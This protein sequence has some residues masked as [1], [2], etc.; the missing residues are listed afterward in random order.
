MAARPF[1]SLF[2]GCV[3]FVPAALASPSPQGP[4]NTAPFQVLDN[5][6]G[7]FVNLNLFPVRPLVAHPSGTGFFALN[8]HASTVERF[9]DTGSAPVEVWPVPWGPVAARLWTHPQTKQTQLLVSCRGSYV[10]ARLDATSGEVLGLIELP[11][12]PADVLVID[13]RA[14]VA[15]TALDTIV[16]VDLLTD[17]TIEY[18]PSSHPGFECKAPLFL[19]RSNSGRV[20]VPPTHS[21]NNSTASRITLRRAGEV[22]D[23]ADPN[24]AVQGLPDVDMYLIDP[25]A[26]T[27]T[28]VGRA[29]GTTLFGVAN[30]PVTTRTWVLNTDAN[31]KGPERQGEAAVR[32][33]VVA[34]RLSII[35]LNSTDP[36]PIPELIVDLDDIDPNQRGTQHLASEAVGQPFQ[37]DFR[38]NGDAY[39]VGLLTDN[40]VILDKDGQR[41]GEFDLPDGAIPRGV[42]VADAAGVVRIHCWGT[43][44]VLEYAL[45]DNSLQ[46]TCELSDDP[47]PPLVA[48]GR[49]LFYDASHSLHGNASCASCHVEGRTD[50]LVWNLDDEPRDKKGPLLTQSM[51]GL[52]RLAPFHWRGERDELA[53]FNPAFDGLLGGEPLEREEF[54][55]FEAFVMSLVN[56]AN[57][58]STRDRQLDDARIPYTIAGTA[59]AVAGQNA[60]INVPVPNGQFCTTCHALPLGTNHDIFGGEPTETIAKRVFNKVAPFNELHRR[61]MGVVPIETYVEPGNPGAGTVQDSRGYLG[62]A[63]THA[64]LIE[65]F[66]K[67]IDDFGDG[68]IVDNL[69][70]F[71]MQLDQGLAPAIHEA[72]LLDAGTVAASATD[73]QGFLMSAAAAR[74]CD[75]VVFGRSEPGAVRARWAW[76]RASDTFVPDHASLTPRTLAQFVAA[77]ANESHVFLGVPVGT[78]ARFA[79]DRDLDGL[80]NALDTEPLVPFVDG[81]DSAAPVFTVAPH[82]VWV[83]AKTARVAFETNEPTSYRVLYGEGVVPD[84][85]S[86][87]SPD[88]D[89]LSEW[90]TAHAPLLTGLL[91][92]TAETN[93][94][95]GLVQHS[96]APVVEIVD[97]AGNVTSVTMAAFD[98][99]PFG[100]GSLDEA[101]LGGLHWRMFDDVGPGP[102]R[103]RVQAQAIYKRGPIPQPPAAGRLVVYRV[104][105]DGQV[106]DTW[107]PLG[108]D[109]FRV[110]H[111]EML[112]PTGSKPLDVPGPFLVGFETDAQGIVRA[113]FELANAQLGQEVTAN[114]EAVILLNANALPLLHSNLAA[115]SACA[116]GGGGG[117]VDCDGDGQPDCCL[118]VPVPFHVRS[119]T[120]WSF[121]DTRPAFRAL[122]EVVNPMDETAIPLD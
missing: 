93:G 63:A 74:H 64:G 86:P 108:A 105:V 43:N 42:Q 40:V 57:P 117:T 50:F 85:C 19:A 22:I 98:S 107:T 70:S 44:Q 115:T 37:I 116:T 24:V 110:D 62:V 5:I 2:A 121:P 101:I 46:R 33:E 100:P 106:N 114:V 48:E 77:A 69:T 11:A 54:A 36:P 52:A 45:A 118:E 80:V 61:L 7:A 87:S 27:V 111:I 25:N 92:G 71:V 53:D 113:G 6:E 34:N 51:S 65:S 90:G 96:Y 20:L 66:T 109:S 119:L 104:L 120:N 97:R 26:Q 49:A 29:I 3:L 55:A 41:L 39:I 72:F 99:A 122:S 10:L 56:P 28:P 102:L 30:N 75:V 83:T 4:A 13:D 12:E 16:Q 23:L 47:T 73:L 89:V 67:R 68:P 94:A 60:Y 95:F 59:S 38:A 58:Y 18:S 1:C 91:P 31:N 9:T 21:G 78:G 88:C 112:G 17:A 32:G 14:F 81:Q 35:R 82:L 8:T 15:C 76:D 103:A 79:I 84:R